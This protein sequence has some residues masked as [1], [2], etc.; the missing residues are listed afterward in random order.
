MTTRAVSAVFRYA[1]GAIAINFGMVPAAGAGSGGA[2]RPFF[3]TC[4]LARERVHFLRARSTN[5]NRVTIGI[6]WHKSV[7]LLSKCCAITFPELWCFR[8]VFRVD[9]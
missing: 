5:Y 9:S 4:P 3:G 8:F 6:A 7:S 1:A 2:V